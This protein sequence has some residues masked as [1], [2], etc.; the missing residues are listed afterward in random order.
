MSFFKQWRGAL[1]VAAG[2]FL[3]LV[4]AYAVQRFV[5]FPAFE[6]LERE[7]ARSNVIRCEENLKRELD[8]LDKM[9]HDW[10][11]W[12]DTY[13]FVQDRNT[14]YIQSNIVSESLQ[15]SGLDLIYVC[16]L[17]GKIIL[18][19]TFDYQASQSYHLPELPQDAL[20]LHHP[21]LQHKN[22]NFA[23]ILS[24]GRG[25]LLLV[26]RPILPSNAGAAPRGTLIM[27][28]F[29]DSAAI[30]L[31]SKRILV[32]F[33]IHAT[34]SPALTPAAQS[35]VRE[36]SASSSREIIEVRND[37]LFH[38]KAIHDIYGNPALLLE[39]K[40]T[41]N[42][43]HQG[44]RVTTHAFGWMLAMG[45]ILLVVFAG[46]QAERARKIAP[47]ATSLRHSSSLQMTTLA[48][49]VGLTLTGIIFGIARA[50]ALQLQQDQ[51]SAKASAQYDL[52]I[53]TLHAHLKSL[54]FIQN[55]F[56]A[57]Q[58][59][60]PDE[61]R[62]FVGNTLAA[63]PDIHIFGW[64]PLA[65]RS[66]KK[67]PRE[68]EKDHYPLH[69]VEP[70]EGS[71]NLLKFDLGADPACLEA[72]EKARD[73]GESQA[74]PIGE[75]FSGTDI[76]K[77]KGFFV[78]LPVYAKNTSLANSDE[79]KKNLQGLVVGALHSKAITRS[80]LEL[81][82]EAD[83]LTCLHNVHASEA[84]VRDCLSHAFKNNAPASRWHDQHHFSFAGQS[85]ILSSIPTKNF[86]QSFSFQAHWTILPIGILIT[87]LIALYIYTIQMRY[88]TTEALIQSRTHDLQR[89]LKDLEEKSK[90]MEILN[91]QFQESAERAQQLALEANVANQAKSSFLA[92]MSHEIR[93]PMNSVIGIAQ[94]L[95]DTSLTPQQKEYI[96]TIEKSGEIL[97]SII[98]DILDF[99]KFEANK[100][101]VEIIP[102]NLPSVLN[103]V[104][105]L[106]SPKASEKNISFQCKRDPHLPE[107]VLGDAL[108][109]KQVLFNLVGNAIKFTE[110]GGV[111]SETKL[112]RQKDNKALL[113][114][115][116]TDTGIG[117]DAQTR[118][119][120]FKEFTQ[121]DSSI[122]RKFGG[123]GLGLVISKKIINRMGGRILVQSHPGMGSCFSV[124]LELPLASPPSEPS[125][126]SKIPIKVPALKILL[127]EDNLINQEIM[128]EILQKD[129]HQV[130]AANNGLQ[131]LEIL[132]K[133][134]FDVI[135]MDMQM[136]ELDGLETTMRIRKLNP[137]QAQIPIIAL[138][139]NVMTEDRQQCLAAG[140]NGYIAKPVYRNAL[141]IELARVLHLQPSKIS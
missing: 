61:F 138:T 70:H 102:F 35:A 33:S 59:V 24:T 78:F 81:T 115:S 67:L 56:N 58:F 20:E 80:A 99:S 133:E 77:E 129:G 48:I 139:A 110:K 50:R 113:T 12:D 131:V 106:M 21:L 104:C 72:I 18:S 32:D 114:F 4:G 44:A 38:Y 112:I 121:A 60:D 3:F 74:T 126:E 75:L 47:M 132:Q 46:W 17:K 83:I 42:I 89:A 88:E 135:L 23:G 9:L 19:Y 52:V 27:G 57:S 41:R 85:F 55:F 29:L 134:T 15:G 86:I 105:R 140:M 49:L 25:P 40:Q 119:N 14:D 95:E 82:N 130:I 125:T 2:F 34:S 128:K 94:L 68:N 62:A 87:A 100:F 71:E 63:S 91:T 84:S 120:L 66:S 93:T 54:T 103:D 92:T 30:Q 116:I 39:V 76:C 13:Q 22:K 11:T 96:Q 124:H 117:M 118:M 53:N 98:N 31:I 5:I 137:P 65:P 97:L 64:A 107:W 136:P 90:E 10:A 28:R 69:Y 127:A 111:T 123:T 141:N 51:F 37:A 6:K 26:A 101:E 36:L 16:D 122:S 79:R 109:I 108:R 7:N 1:I 73:T 8:H 43:T 45:L